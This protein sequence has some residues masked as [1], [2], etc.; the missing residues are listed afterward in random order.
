MAENS[1]ARTPWRDNIEAMT[2]AIIMAVFLKY[3]IVEAYKIPTG[4]MQ[5]TLMGETYANG[6]GI[7]DR[8]LV[9]KLSYH[10][11]DPERFEITVFRYPLDRSKNFV[12]RL[13]GMPG[14]ELR[15]QNG[16]LL[17]RTSPDQP[18]S[19]PRRSRSV[20][21]EMW[22]AIEAHPA[23]PGPN[24]RA[25]TGT[26]WIFEGSKVGARG[27]GSAEFVGHGGGPIRDQY[28]HG[29]PQ[30]MQSK[31]IVP[32]QVQSGA[33]GV[34]DLRCTGKITAQTGC[35]TVSLTLI[36]GP[37]SYRFVIPGPEAAAETRVELVITDDSGARSEFGEPYRLGS[38]RAT[39]LDVQNLDDRLE[40]RLN[41]KVLIEVPVQPCEQQDGGVQI[42]VEGS[43]ADFDDLRVFRDVYYTPGSGGSAW[44]IPEG[45]YFMLGDNTQNS[46]DCREWAFVHLRYEDEDGTE[47]SVRGNWR[48]AMGGTRLLEANPIRHASEL[49]PRTWIRD[50]WGEMHEFPSASERPLQPGTFRTTVHL[51]PRELIVGRAVFVFWPLSPSKG[52]YRWKWAH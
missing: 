3:F 45:N 4:S 42:A 5:P 21:G 36:E 10:L 37:R 11:R 31:V 34:G 48:P 23:R 41:G 50:E 14:E 32:P 28:T 22:K 35:R 17:V 43:G 33:N 20:M 27:D 24:W 19:I 16:D 13:V 29:Y 49:G 39:K 51:V 18:W 44:T 26:G 8:I 9:D 46:S 2:G 52:V 1:K 38:D 40:L 15:I 47:R 30:A 25:M 7:W 6:D 12:K